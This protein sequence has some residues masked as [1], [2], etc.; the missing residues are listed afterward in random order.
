[1]FS[2]NA[3]QNETELILND[4]S[5]ADLTF[6]RFYGENVK[7]ISLNAFGKATK[8]IRFFVCFYCNLQNQQPKYDIWT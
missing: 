7:R 6:N 1:M 3:T 2:T 8:T 5:F 4:N